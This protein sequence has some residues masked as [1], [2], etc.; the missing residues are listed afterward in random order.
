M[1]Y[2]IPTGVI[3]SSLS[4]LEDRLYDRMQSSWRTY[5]RGSA[6]II[7]IYGYN[8]IWP[9]ILSFVIGQYFFNHTA[10]VMFL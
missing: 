10:G 5:L 4:L 6:I 9:E 7:N 1:Q 3:C 8:C 2:R